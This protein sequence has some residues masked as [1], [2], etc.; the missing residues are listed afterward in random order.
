MNHCLT[1]DSDALP[2]N[3]YI[4]FVTWHAHDFVPEVE[5]K[6]TF[7]I[8][9]FLNLFWAGG[10]WIGPYQEY[11]CFWLESNCDKISMNMK[12]S[13]VKLSLSSNL[14]SYLWSNQKLYAL[15]T[16]CLVFCFVLFLTFVPLSH[17]NASYLSKWIE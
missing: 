15:H 1:T 8:N 5:I 12:N 14:K 11:V 4:V 7:I 13:S 2:M 6:R 3:C 9:V 16:N 17:L 10:S